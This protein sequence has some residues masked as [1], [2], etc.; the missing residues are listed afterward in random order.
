MHIAIGFV[1]QTVNLTIMFMFPRGVC[2]LQVSPHVPGI[3]ID[4][5]GTSE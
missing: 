1:S 2:D 3:P 5:N 4:S